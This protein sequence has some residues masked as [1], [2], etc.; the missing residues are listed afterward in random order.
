ML[1]TSKLV[2]K[3][4]NLLTAPVLLF[5]TFHRGFTKF[6]YVCSLNFV[7]AKDQKLPILPTSLNHRSSY[8]RVRRYH[9]LEYRKKQSHWLFCRALSS[10]NLSHQI[11]HCQ[12]RIS[13]W[14]THGKIRRDICL[15]L[16]RCLESLDFRSTF[17]PK[18]ASGF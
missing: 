9:R 12:Q 8:R 11:G 13:R 18:L 17:N 2:F 16:Y 15:A 7:H 5:Q 14:T 6:S 3:N 1:A 4:F 10:G